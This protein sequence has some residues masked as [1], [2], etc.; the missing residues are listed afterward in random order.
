MKFR[1][2]LVLDGTLAVKNTAVGRVVEEECIDL[3]QDR[4]FRDGIYTS[5][6]IV[7]VSNYP[8]R[9]ELKAIFNQFRV[10]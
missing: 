9:K 1:A 6:F 10:S 3:P 8:R 5:A 7:Q 4:C 2:R